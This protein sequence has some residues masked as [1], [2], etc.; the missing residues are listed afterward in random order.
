MSD[1]IL[2]FRETI[3]KH[4]FNSEERAKEIADY[5]T[6]HK[7]SGFSIEDFAKDF[8]IP[9]EDAEII[10]KTIYKGVEFKKNMV[11]KK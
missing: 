2:K 8:N 9:K 5:V 1:Y 4:G 7:K 3:E 10:L 6:D 11:D